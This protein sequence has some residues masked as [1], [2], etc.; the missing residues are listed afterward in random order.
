VLMRFDNGMFEGMPF[1]T[2]HPY[3]KGRAIYLGTAVLDHD[4]YRKIVRHA[5]RLA[6]IKELVLPDGVEVI[7][8]GP[9]TFVLNYSVKTASFDLPLHGLSLTDGSEIRGHLELPPFGY[10][11]VETR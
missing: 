1:L 11:A 5:V 6:S 10:C 2:E 4:A 8:R 3:G 9:V 7:A